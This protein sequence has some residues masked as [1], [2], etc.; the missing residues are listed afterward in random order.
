MKESIV[1]YVILPQNIVSKNNLYCYD[2][3][4]S[5]THNSCYEIK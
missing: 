4:N 3:T 2:L 5:F 1:H